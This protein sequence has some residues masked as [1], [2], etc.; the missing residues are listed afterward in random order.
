M[1]ARKA[2]PPGAILGFKAIKSNSA[3][4]HREAAKGIHD[5]DAEHQDSILDVNAKRSAQEHA[6]WQ[7]LKGVDD[8]I[9]RLNQTQHDDNG[10][11]QHIRHRKIEEEKEEH[12]EVSIDGLLR[13]AQ[14]DETSAE[15]ETEKPLS[16]PSMVHL[17]TEQERINK[18]HA[19]YVAEEA[20]QQAH[21]AAI[22]AKQDAARKAAAKV[23]FA[24]EKKQQAHEA[25]VVSKQNV[26]RQ[27]ADIAN[28]GVTI[29]KGTTHLS[30]PPSAQSGKQT[31][32]KSNTTSDEK[33]KDAGKEHNNS[34]NTPGMLCLTEGG[35]SDQ[36][37]K[38]FSTS[39]VCVGWE[40]K[41][42]IGLGDT[43]HMIKVRCL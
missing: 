39:T 30:H 1:L 28:S 10:G 5:P 3:Y 31:E 33:P 26:A 16:D 25:T 22:V 14:R 20:K 24:E 23:T 7:K 6:R 11:L 27:S 12:K 18:E 40:I 29:V 36:E 8:P 41:R 42:G 19:R 43:V 17:M 13:S 9:A 15:H 35:L 32:R 21:E 4:Y 38:D 2:A 37:L 34:S